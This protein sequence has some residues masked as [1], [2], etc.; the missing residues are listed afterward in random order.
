M[1]VPR[2]L[3]GQV[4]IVTAATAGI[5]RGI[6][7]RLASEG[8]AVMICSR[9]V[10]TPLQ[11]YTPRTQLRGSNYG[12]LWRMRTSRARASKLH[13]PLLR[14]SNE[15]TCINEHPTGPAFTFHP[16]PPHVPDRRQQNVDET[17]AALRQKGLQVS[18]VACHV[19][20]DQHRRQLVEQTIKVSVE[21][22]QG[23]VFDEAAVPG[24]I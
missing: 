20:N 9:Q 23:G 21:Q 7:E 1:E 14:A 17:V 2:R 4:A 6:A 18:G 15:L 11:R 3:Q 12:L 22:Q 5:G 10:Q 13:W 16:P 19:G 24:C 8:A